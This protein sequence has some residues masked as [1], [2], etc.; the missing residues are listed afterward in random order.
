MVVKT[1][2]S[3]DITGFG[4]ILIKTGTREYDFFYPETLDNG[5]TR[6]ICRS[7]AKVHVNFSTTPPTW[8]SVTH[9][10]IETPSGFTNPQISNVS[11]NTGLG[12]DFQTEKILL[13]VGEWV[14]PNAHWYCTDV[15]LLAIDRTTGAVTVLHADLLGLAKTIVSTITQTNLVADAM[16]Y[17]GKI[18][19]ALGCYDPTSG[20]AAH[21]RS[22]MIL[23]NGTTWSAINPKPVQDGI[24]MKAEPIFDSGDSFIGW[25]TDGHGTN[26]IFLKPDFSWVGCKP[27]NTLFST[28]PTF[29]MINH[30]VVWLEWGSGTGSVQHVH[31]A[32]PDVTSG[33]VNFVD[34]TPS[35]SLVDNEGGSRNMTK[36]CKVGSGIFSDETNFWFIMYGYRGDTS[37]L[38]DRAFKCDLGYYNDITH[39]AYLADPTN[40]DQY[41]SVLTRCVNPTTKLLVPNPLIT[42][43]GGNLTL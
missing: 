2:Y 11:L 10:N 15:K 21:D 29:D 18:A 35:G 16:G 33:C 9:I 5:Y 43:G 24:Q 13:V 32:D 31:V 8:G 14:S 23:Y 17:G 19:I 27:P 12:Y 30:K 6:F 42:V 39:W 25:L 7:V 26:S 28:N 34:K 3:H 20:Y 22:I 41:Y 40:L 36:V 1:D 4:G 37:G 38:P